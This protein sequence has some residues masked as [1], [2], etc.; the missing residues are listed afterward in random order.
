MAKKGSEI[1]VAIPFIKY[2]P[3]NQ[4]F[5]VTPDAVEFLK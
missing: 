4:K 1:G 5:E 3:E 2:E